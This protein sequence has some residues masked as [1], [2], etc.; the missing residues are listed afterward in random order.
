MTDQVVQ[1]DLFS[2]L[3]P[4]VEKETSA[5]AAKEILPHV[6]R[7]ASKVWEYVKEQSLPSHDLMPSSR[8]SR[9]YLIWFFF[10]LHC[11]R[12]YPSRPVREI[13]RNRSDA[14]DSMLPPPRHTSLL[15]MI[16]L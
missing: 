13:W 12:S 10:L 6:T 14:L 8:Q 11:L 1:Y 2:G 4:H 15:E 3:P 9:S 5:E 16:V 7:I